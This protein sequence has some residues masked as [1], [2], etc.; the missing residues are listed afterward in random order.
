MTSAAGLTFATVNVVLRQDYGTPFGT[1]HQSECVLVLTLF[2]YIRR[3]FFV[4]FVLKYNIT[5]V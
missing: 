4:V 2:L 1:K 3:Q 5:K